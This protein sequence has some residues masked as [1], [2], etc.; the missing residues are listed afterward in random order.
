MSL[1]FCILGII[2]SYFGELIRIL[3]VAFIPS[4]TSGRNTKK[5]SAQSL[6]TTG[7]YSIVR[8]PL[9]LGNY[10]ILLGP[11]LF[12]A[13][14]SAIIIY[15][16][17]FWIY[18]ERIM[19][20]EESFLNNKFQEQFSKWAK[21]VPPIIPK[22]NIYKPP[23]GN[24]SFIQV[25]YREYT[26]FCGI[27]FMFYILVHANYFLYDIDIII[28]NFWLPALIVNSFLYIFLRLF[29]KTRRKPLNN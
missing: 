23:E 2:I 10:F 13:N 21:Q 8:H 24:F 9:Y 4:L 3:T 29:K 26:G 22:F 19:Y 5:Q 11:F 12:I 7:I 28:I 6:N 1:N 20:A 14:P 15:T 27:L 17:L 25:I 18:Y 16:L